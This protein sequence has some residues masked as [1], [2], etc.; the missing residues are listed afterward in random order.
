[1]GR[2]DGHRAQALR[3]CRLHVTAMHELPTSAL[4]SRGYP[5]PGKSDTQSDSNMTGSIAPRKIDTNEKRSERFWRMESDSDIAA[6]AALLA[7]RSPTYAPRTDHQQ[8]LSLRLDVLV[9]DWE[10]TTAKHA[11]DLS[12]FPTNRPF[13]IASVMILQSNN[14]RMLMSSRPTTTFTPIVLLPRKRTMCS[15]P[16]LAP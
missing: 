6:K 9:Q 14:R 4:S 2:K 11:T 10:V 8:Q 7:S 13:V 12:S 3:S 5:G 1:M 16:G 15:Q